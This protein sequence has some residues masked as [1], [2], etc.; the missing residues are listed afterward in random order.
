M[1]ILRLVRD[2][3]EV[4]R[5]LEALCEPTG[6]PKRAPARAPPYWASRTLRIRSLEDEVA[7][8]AARPAAPCARRLG[9]LE[10]RFVLHLA[11]RQALTPLNSG[12]LKYVT[13]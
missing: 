8:V 10:A 3:D 11:R 12:H 9:D 2:Q 4:R 13:F 7:H 5:L 1:R 6:P